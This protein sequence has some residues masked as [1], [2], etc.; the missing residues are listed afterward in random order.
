[1]EC[2]IRQALLWKLRD[3]RN[4]CQVD[5][6]AFLLTH[7]ERESLYAEFIRSGGTPPKLDRMMIFRFHNIPVIENEHLITLNTGES[8]AKKK[9][10]GG[11]KGGC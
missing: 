10:K 6:V 2:T 4:K 8:M 5:P 9:T 7:Q 3:W 11:K 1:M